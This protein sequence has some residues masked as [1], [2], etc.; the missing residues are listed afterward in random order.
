MAKHH[1]ENDPFKEWNEVQDHR[2]DPGYWTGGRV[3][4]VYRRRPGG[5]RYGWLLIPSGMFFVAL[6]AAG[7]R[8]PN[9]GWGIASALLAF[10]FGV[11]MIAGGVRL[12]GSKSE[13]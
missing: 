6:S 10:L 11:A 8:N 1:E 12:L 3:H 5:N 4:P 2:Y 13:K 9:P 7:L